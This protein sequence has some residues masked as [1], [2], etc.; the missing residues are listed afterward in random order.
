MLNLHA[1]I[2]NSF[3][4]LIKHCMLIDIQT[5]KRYFFFQIWIDL[6]LCYFFFINHQRWES[7]RISMNV[8]IFIIIIIIILRI[9]I[10]ISI[11]IFNWTYKKREKKRKKNNLIKYVYTFLW[12]HLCKKLAT[13]SKN[14]MKILTKIE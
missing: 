10:I 8:I 4:F 2:E 12:M 9:F 13:L 6:K 11:I 1:T 5:S 14:F 7:H 3:K